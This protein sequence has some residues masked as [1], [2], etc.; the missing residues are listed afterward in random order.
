[1]CN[2]LAL[3]KLKALKEYYKVFFIEKY[4]VCI[5]IN[6]IHTYLDL[7]VSPVTIVGGK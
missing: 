7:F 5:M 2:N 3:A 6:Y 4:I 1:M